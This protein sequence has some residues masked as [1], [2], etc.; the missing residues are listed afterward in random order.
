MMGPGE[1][2][3]MAKAFV[4]LMM[5]YTMGNQFPSDSAHLLT[6]LGHGKEAVRGLFKRKF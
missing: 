3:I 5:V 2:A 1:V 6:K 4:M